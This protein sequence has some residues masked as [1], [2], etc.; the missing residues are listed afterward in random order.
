MTTES[1]MEA[2]PES[3][4]AVAI[5]HLSKTFPGQRALIDVDFTVRP[6]EVHALLGQ[7]GS[8]KSTLIRILAGIYKP[9][10][11]AEIV[12]GGEHLK[13]GSPRDS[14]RLGLR[15][16]HQTL[17]I[18]GELTA[19]ENVA[20]GTGY[21]RVGRHFVDW[22]GQRAKTRRLLA[23]LGVDFDIE[24][25]VNTLRPVDRSAIAI[26]RALDTESEVSRVLVL[27]EPTAALPLSEVDALFSL[28]EQARNAGTSVIYVTHRLQEV[29]RLADRATVLR[30]GRVRGV[31]GIGGID[32]DTMVKLIVG[33]ELAA[34]LPDHLTTL[35]A[36]DKRPV[37]LEIQG[38]ASRRIHS[39]DVILRQGEIL[40]VT[41]LTGSGREE[42]ARALVGAIPSRVRLLTKDNVAIVDPS[43]RQAMRRGVCLVLPSGV[44]G[45]GSHD[46]T[47]REN[48][49]LPEMRRYSRAGFIRYR[50]ETDVARH[51][52]KAL[53]IR[54]NDPERA[55]RLLSGGNQQ[56]VVFSKWLG[57]RPDVLI[58]DEP[59]SGVDV[60]ARETIY[61]LIRGEAA[62]GKAFIVCSSDTED[63]LAVCTRVLV[64]DSG[65]IKAELA[66][67]D[68]GESRIVKEM[69]GAGVSAE[70]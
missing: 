22:R 58:L 68:V 27:D 40:G 11:G 65:M 57:L 52:I 9:D 55:M 16:V 33:G 32:R 54:P 46:L 34:S 62:S 10:P 56:K 38:L 53:D 48:I 30:D 61:E 13:L 23:L 31:A 1:N 60:G 70:A 45:A 26:A 41:G 63:L 29:E 4:A 20:L 19:V 64:L 35:K 69:M 28:V 39:I 6:A 17:G 2:V 25:P 7:N 36:V 8:G 59:T 49:T 51:W 15:F 12:V 50:D 14:R 37:A 24:C 18:I 67:A 43:P 5:T 66:G 42:M 21:L 44:P 47:V 3:L